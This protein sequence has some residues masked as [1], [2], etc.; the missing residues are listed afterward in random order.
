MMALT[1]EA[2]VPAEVVATL[3]STAGIL[4]AV[5]LSDV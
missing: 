5:A 3:R 1:F 2:A 4:D